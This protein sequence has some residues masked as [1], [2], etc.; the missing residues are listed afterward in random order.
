MTTFNGKI[1]AI[2]GAA[3]GIGLATVEAL[4][5]AGAKVVMIDR[6]RKALDAH[7]ARLG[8]QANRE[9]SCR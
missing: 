1:A 9:T 8:P 7:C 3:S 6:D 2:T 4:I 5:A